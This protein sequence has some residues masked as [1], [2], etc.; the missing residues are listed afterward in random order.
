MLKAQENDTRQIV[1]DNHRFSRFSRFLDFR[2]FMLVPLSRIPIFIHFQMFQTSQI[3]QILK[4]FQLYE[5]WSSLI[6]GSNRIGGWLT[7]RMLELVLL[8]LVRRVRRMTGFQR[9]PEEVH[10]AQKFFDTC[11]RTTGGTTVLESAFQEEVEQ[12]LG[13][14]AMMDGLASASRQSPL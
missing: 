7:R 14:W 9:G 2:I 11:G 12:H 6:S 8:H 3:K 1:I 5:K 4:N 13:T 10:L